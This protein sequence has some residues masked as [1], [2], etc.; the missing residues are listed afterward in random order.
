M[1]VICLK[2]EFFFWIIQHNLFTYILPYSIFKS[3]PSFLC[4]SVVLWSVFQ[5]SSK[6]YNSDITI[7]M[8]K[9]Q[10]TFIE[11][12]H[13]YTSIAKAQKDMHQMAPA[14]LSF[15]TWCLPF[16]EKK[17]TVS[18]IHTA[19]RINHIWN[20]TPESLFKWSII[21]A[22]LGKTAIDPQG[23]PLL[24]ITQ[25]KRHNSFSLDRF[26]CWNQMSLEWFFSPRFTSVVEPASLLCTSH[27]LALILISS[28]HLLLV[29]YR[30]SWLIKALS[31]FL[32]SY[33]VSL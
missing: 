10:Q 29:G 9:A 24:A 5:T 31:F 23:Y 30:I 21:N 7:N 17:W 18:T 14:M 28:L 6:M 4:L 19:R 2:E 1:D 27:L 22:V 12:A 16:F 15:Y 20:L 32:S 8:K 25:R 11:S 13:V 3:P 26:V 33:A